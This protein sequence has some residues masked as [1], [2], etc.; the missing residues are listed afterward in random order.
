VYQGESDA[1]PLSYHQRKIRQIHLQEAQLL[2]TNRATMYCI[3]FRIN[4]HK[5]RQMASQ[6]SL[7]KYTLLLYVVT[8]S[9][10]CVTLHD[11]ERNFSYTDYV[12]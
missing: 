9:L 1:P 12:W 7:Y 11:L 8:L 6:L 5:K 2:Q 3:L 10:F 4:T